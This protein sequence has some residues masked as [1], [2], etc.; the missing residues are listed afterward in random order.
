MVYR[1]FETPGVASFTGPRRPAGLLL[2]R[3]VKVPCFDFRG[4]KQCTMSPAQSTE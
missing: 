3:K 2:G 4:L 1:P